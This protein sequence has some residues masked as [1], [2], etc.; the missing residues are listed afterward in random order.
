MWA[1]SCYWHQA[2]APTTLYED[3]GHDDDDHEDDGDDH[4][5]DVHNEYDCVA[6][7]D[8]GEDNRPTC[9]PT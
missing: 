6:D 4:C 2:R 1:E 5:G 9:W 8:D 7:G 3:R